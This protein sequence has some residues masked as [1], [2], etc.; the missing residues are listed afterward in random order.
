MKLNNIITLIYILAI[1]LFSYGEH[2]TYNLVGESCLKGA[3]V[4]DV[5]KKSYYIGEWDSS[6]KVHKYKDD[7][8]ELY[9]LQESQWYRPDAALVIPAKY[10]DGFIK[11][12]QSIKEAMEKSSG[13]SNDNFTIADGNFEFISIDKKGN[14]YEYGTTMGEIQCHSDRYWMHFNIGKAPKFPY[15]NCDKRSW[16]NFTKIDELNSLINVL[17]ES[18]R[19]DNTGITPD[20]FQRVGTYSTDLESINKE[21]RE[22]L[23]SGSGLKT[24]YYIN[25]GKEYIDGNTYTQYLW[26]K[27]QYYSAF[28]KWMN[29]IFT[30]YYKASMSSNKEFQQSI[31]IPA[32]LKLGGL[33]TGRFDAEMQTISG[34]TLDSGNTKAM[35]YYN[36]MKN[37]YSLS[38]QFGESSMYFSSP[39]QFKNFI[40][41]LGK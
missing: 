30:D 7:N 34:G 27:G 8:V 14:T 4:P 24:K 36:N 10:I 15:V 2:K 41:A 19:K 33:I 6:N 13:G 3:T 9:L 25:V 20:D 21:K 38:F 31:Q 29:E 23:R 16:L 12:L 5:I 22:I 17:S 39:Q 1:P 28:K 35:I 26:F 37:R 40:N 18:S 11:S 32:N